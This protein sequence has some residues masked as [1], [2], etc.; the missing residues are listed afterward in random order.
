M[1]SGDTDSGVLRVQAAV[2]DLVL[3]PGD[4]HVGDT[5]RAE[6]DAFVRYIM[7]GD[8]DGADLRVQAAV[9]DLVLPPGEESTGRHRE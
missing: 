2:N 5:L 4:S 9:N 1:L 6:W 8:H 3:P 7:H